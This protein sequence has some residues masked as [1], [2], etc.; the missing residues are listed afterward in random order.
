[1]RLQLLLLALAYIATAFAVSVAHSMSIHAM[2][3]PWR[4]RLRIDDTEEVFVGAEAER[5]IFL[6]SSK[7]W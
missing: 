5:D 6:K 1:M 2:M 3:L 7:W 4:C